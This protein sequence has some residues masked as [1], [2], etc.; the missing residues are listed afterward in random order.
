MY[1]KNP[2]IY[3]RTTDIGIDQFT[4]MAM[5]LPLTFRIRSNS[6]QRFMTIQRKTVHT[7]NKYIKI[8][9]LG[10]PIGGLAGLLGSM[11]GV[12]GGVIMVLGP[13]VVIFNSGVASYKFI[14][15][16]SYGL[17]TSVTTSE[18]CLRY[19]IGRRRR[20]WARVRGAVVF[21]SRLVL[22]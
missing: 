3:P 1:K 9:A 10:I 18:A 6:I 12:G 16:S 5:Y 22:I 7:E 17:Q 8:P 20:D 2:R 19:V 15:G 13:S 14:A 4:K 21:D 11:L